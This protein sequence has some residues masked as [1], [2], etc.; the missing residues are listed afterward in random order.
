[1]ALSSVDSGAAIGRDLKLPFLLRS[2][3]VC[4]DFGIKDGERRR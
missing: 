1:V 3:S 4:D 2:V